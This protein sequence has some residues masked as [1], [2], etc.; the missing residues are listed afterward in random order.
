MRRWGSQL[1][2]GS[3]R[4]AESQRVA[5]TECPSIR[6]ERD[7]SRPDRVSKPSSKVSME[8]YEEKPPD[9]GANTSERRGRYP[10]PADDE[11]D[12]GEA[13]Q[14]YE[15]AQAIHLRMATSGTKV[16][17]RRC[18]TQRRAKSVILNS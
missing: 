2:R 1:C 4:G 10:D 17:T 8:E 11:N 9:K 12:N 3:R 15:V 5:G 6:L 13:S 7:C 16:S 14:A 18:K